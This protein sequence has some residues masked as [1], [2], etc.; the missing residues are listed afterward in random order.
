MVHEANIVSIWGRQDTDGPHV[1]PMNFPIWDVISQHTKDAGGDLM[2]HED[3]YH[4]WCDFQM[5]TLSHGPINASISQYYYLYNAFQCSLCFIISDFTLWFIP[6]NIWLLVQGYDIDKLQGT[7]TR[8]NLHHW[9]LRWVDVFWGD[10]RVGVF[11][12]IGSIPCLLM[13]WFLKSPG[14]EHAL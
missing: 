2:A 4:P 1:G 12:F 3:W 7:P 14:H 10:T 8:S 13:H 11:R 9:V 6:K 5:V